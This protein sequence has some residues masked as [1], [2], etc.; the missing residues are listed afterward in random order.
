[1]ELNEKDIE[2][3]RT[4]IKHFY[5]EEERH[6]EENDRPEEHIYLYLEHFN[7]RLNLHLRDKSYDESLED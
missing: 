3:L 1:M 2:K 4:I 7:E 5:P 6:W